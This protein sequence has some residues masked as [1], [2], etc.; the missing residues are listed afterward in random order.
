MLF[1]SDNSSGKYF[2]SPA[3]ESFSGSAVTEIQLTGW[4]YVGNGAIGSAS[5]Y[6]RLHNPGEDKELLG[7]DFRP[8][9]ISFIYK[10]DDSAKLVPSSDATNGFYENPILKFNFDDTVDTDVS[11]FD[12]F[13]GERILFKDAN[14]YS[15]MKESLGFKPNV[16][17]DVWANIVRRYTTLK[18]GIGGTFY[19]ENFI[20]EPPYTGLL[21]NLDSMIREQNIGGANDIDHLC[22]DGLYVYYAYGINIYCV[23]ADTGTEQWSVTLSSAASEMCTDG[24]Y[25]YIA[26]DSTT[27]A[28]KIYSTHDGSELKTCTITSGATCNGLAANGVRLIAAFGSVVYSWEVDDASPISPD[29]NTDHGVTI[30]DVCIDDKYS[31][32]AGATALDDADIR[33]LNNFNGLEFNSIDLDQIFSSHPTAVTWVKTDG[34]RLY[35]SMSRTQFQSGTDYASV[36][37]MSK[38]YSDTSGRACDFIWSFDTG[39]DGQNIVIDDRSLCANYNDKFWELNKVD[40]HVKDFLSY[41]RNVI[42]DDTDG[43]SLF[44]RENSSTDYDY[45]VRI[46]F[47]KNAT[48]YQRVK[49]TDISRRP[50]YKLAVPCRER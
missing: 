45:W 25:L 47:T 34:E 29:W 35:I 39:Q 48:L 23:D 26:F 46:S 32:A 18:D 41:G 11:N 12:I 19:P 9:S 24:R 36:L 14:P 42:L 20:V 4:F 50:F 49:D 43:I 8:I 7:S 40:G 38:P 2:A 22:T 16:H 15:F 13:C 21:E 44:L 3:T 5:K 10:S 28:V 1:R 37:A 17:A 33:I 31:Y 30:Q 6:F 27:N